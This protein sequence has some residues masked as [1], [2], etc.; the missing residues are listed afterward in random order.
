MKKYKIIKY[1]NGLGKEFYCIKERK[2]L[3]RWNYLKFTKNINL[4]NGNLTE[5]A[6]TFDSIERAEN[7][8]NRIKKEGKINING[9]VIKRL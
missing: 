5:E 7:L 4:I 3:F 9:E 6:Y 2:N 1:R 8:I